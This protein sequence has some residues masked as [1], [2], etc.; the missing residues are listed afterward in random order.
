MNKLSII[1]AFYSLLVT[2]ALAQEA[3]QDS[4]RDF[5]RI[6]QLQNEESLHYF[7]LERR[8]LHT[9]PNLFLATEKGRVTETRRR[10]SDFEHYN[11]SVDTLFTQ[12]ARTRMKQLI[13]GTHEQFE[14][15]SLVKRRLVSAEV[16]LRSNALRYVFSGNENLQSVFDSIVPIWREDGWR[17]SINEYK[18][19]IRVFL[20]IDTMMVF[21]D[22]HNF[23]IE[24]ERQRLIEEYTNFRPGDFNFPTEIVNIAGFLGDTS[25]IPVLK[26]TLYYMPN[27]RAIIEALVRLRAEPYFSNFLNERIVNL[28]CGEHFRDR[29]GL[30]ARLIIDALAEVHTSQSAFREISRYLLLDESCK[31]LF[32]VGGRPDQGWFSFREYALDAIRGLLE[33]EEIVTIIGCQFGRPQNEEVYQKLYDWM[34]TNYGNYIIRR[35]PHWNRIER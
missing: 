5:I 7:R 18:D 31:F 28:D 27:N 17:T 24:Q 13:L 25:F 4:I 2:S 11:L 8:S 16:M 6:G 19:S 3:L 33:N 10:S 14:I 30:T 29:R 20:R 1:F 32:F 21:V 15:D 9:D 22:R 34:Q 23:E 26:Q 12:T 35:Q